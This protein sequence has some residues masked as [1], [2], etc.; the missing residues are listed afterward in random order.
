MGE[1]DQ[2]VP[3]TPVGMYMGLVVPI[4]ESSTIQVGGELGVSMYAGDSYT[5]E[6]QSNGQTHFVDVYEEDCF[7]HY[8]A[9]ARYQPYQEM[10]FMPYAE[11]RLGATSFF[12]TIMADDE[13]VDYFQDESKFHGTSFQTGVGGGMLIDLERLFGS[14]NLFAVDLGATYVTGSRT[15]YRNM[16]LDSG[17]PMKSLDDAKYESTTDNVNFRIGVVLTPW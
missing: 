4:N 8:T 16:S 14:E 2:Y 5:Q 11:F 12:S 9:L 13:Y 15:D 17:Q 1:F 7:F 3:N 10:A 6:V